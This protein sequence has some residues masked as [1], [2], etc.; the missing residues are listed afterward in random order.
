MA[1]EFGPTEVT[2][3]NWISQAEWEVGVR[4]DG[5]ITEER[6]TLIFA[7]VF[8]GTD[9]DEHVWN[10]LKNNAVRRLSIASPDELHDVVLSHLRFVQKPPDRV[11]SYFNSETPRHAI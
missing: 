10:D 2:I 6:G 5:L 7:S 8:A 4:T 1:K 11:R 9:S 3:R